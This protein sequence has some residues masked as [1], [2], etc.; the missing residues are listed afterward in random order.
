MEKSVA[1]YTHN[2]TRCLTNKS[3]FNIVVEDINNTIN[4]LDSV[5]IKVSNPV[6]TVFNCMLT[7]KIEGQCQRLRQA[8]TTH[9]FC[10]SLAKFTKTL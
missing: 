2:V 3:F 7:Q 4:Q 5:S 10:Y 8:K 1:K 9:G 6:H